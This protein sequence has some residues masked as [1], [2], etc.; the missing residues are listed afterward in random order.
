[1]LL[2]E[3]REEGNYLQKE[4]VKGQGRVREGATKESE[5]EKRC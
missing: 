1:M 4:R 2:E 5:G 3:E